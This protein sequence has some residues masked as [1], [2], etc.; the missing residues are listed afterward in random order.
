MASTGEVG[1]I[2]EN[3][4]ETLMFALNATGIILEGKNILITLGPI[5]DKVDMLSSVRTL[6]ALGYT[7]YT[8]SG[9]HDIFAQE[10]IE[11]IALERRDA[12]GNNP[13]LEMIDQKRFDLIINSP[14]GNLREEEKSGYSIRRKAVDRK[15]PL[16][17]NVKLAKFFIRSLLAEKKVG[18][19][20][21]HSYQE[22]MR[23]PR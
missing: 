7:L 8:T 18:Q 22:Y 1:C 21:V 15:I 12:D 14:S 19:F 4:Q 13:I 11:T 3:T 23:H 20:P 17:T 9:T 16:I 10:G 2:G 6:Q 5:A